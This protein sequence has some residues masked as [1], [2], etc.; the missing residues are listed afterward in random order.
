MQTFEDETQE[1]E[2]HDV[3]IHDVEMHDLE[4]HDLLRPRNA[5]TQKCFDSE[6]LR[7]NN[8]LIEN[9]VFFFLSDAGV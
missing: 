5:S 1:L 9:V 6:M 4:M 7:P 8:A 2:L 3:E